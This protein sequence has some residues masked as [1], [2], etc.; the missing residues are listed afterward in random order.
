M[1]YFLKSVST[2]FELP[3]T[4]PRLD[5]MIHLYSLVNGVW[6]HFLVTGTASEHSLSTCVKFRRLVLTLIVSMLVEGEFFLTKNCN[7]EQLS[8]IDVQWNQ[9][10][11]IWPNTSYVD[12]PANETKKLPNDQSL[13]HIIHIRRWIKF[14]SPTK[15]HSLG[16]SHCYPLLDTCAVKQ[17]HIHPHSLERTSVY[18]W[19]IKTRLLP[20]CYCSFSPCWLRAVSFGLHETTAMQKFANHWHCKSKHESKMFCPQ[21]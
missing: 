3:D 4:K 21:S 11:N 18:V 14:P 10:W 20:V 12:K 15:R 19:Q 9:R 5:F 16:W 8:W 1:L 17:S 6:G 13:I 7:V 2:P